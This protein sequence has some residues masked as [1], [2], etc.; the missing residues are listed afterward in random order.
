LIQGA[1]KINEDKIYIP[2]GTEDPPEDFRKHFD[3]NWRYEKQLEENK[4]IGREP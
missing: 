1:W 4:G 3:S 2:T